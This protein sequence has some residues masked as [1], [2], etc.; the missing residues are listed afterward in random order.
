[1]NVPPGLFAAALMILAWRDVGPRAPGDV[2]Y[3]GAVLPSAC[4]VALLLAMF[5]LS[6]GQGGWTSPEFWL[7]VTLAA[8]LAASLIWVE[9]RAANPIVPVKLFGQ[10]LFA[11]ATSHGFLAG[12]SLFDSSAFIPFFA[13]TVLGTSATVA[14]ATFMPMTLSRVLAS[15]VGTRLLLK[16]N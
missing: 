16:V 4:V 14:G 10:R 9:R 1:M 11:I 12:F 5:R 6:N 8:V 13:Q 3:A 7:L 15:I 2:D